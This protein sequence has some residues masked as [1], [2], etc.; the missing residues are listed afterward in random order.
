MWTVFTLYAFIYTLVLIIPWLRNS[1]SHYS[2][3]FIDSWIMCL[4]GIVNTFTEHRWGREGWHRSDYQHT[5]MG[6][7]SGLE[8]F[9]EYFY[10]EVVEENLFQVS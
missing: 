5:T 2:Q 3:D 6:I 1:K 4:W 7:P 8:N 9:W 10:R